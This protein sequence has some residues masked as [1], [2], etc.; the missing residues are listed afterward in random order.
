MANQKDPD[1]NRSSSEILFSTSGGEPAAPPDRSGLTEILAEVRRIGERVDALV[2]ELRQLRSA[3]EGA[4]KD[5]SVAE[6]RSRLDE[7]STKT[8]Q[9]YER[10]LRGIA[11]V[12][13]AVRA[14]GSERPDED[15]AH[16][17]RLA[18]TSLVGLAETIRGLKRRLSESL[19]P[20]ERAAASVEEVTGALQG[21]A[22]KLD[23]VAVR[24]ARVLPTVEETRKAV[25][26][27][28]I[29]LAIGFGAMSIWLLVLSFALE[30]RLQIFSRLFG[31]D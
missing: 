30:M 4:E 20:I 28:E 15:I 22:K 3:E 18:E 26:K 6:M 14:S 12:E 19:E 27:L 10:L 13:A 9:A 5:A 11:E 7:L 23:E 31:A 2:E 16:R 17:L 25:D 29:S 24:N 21:T 1:R 8:K